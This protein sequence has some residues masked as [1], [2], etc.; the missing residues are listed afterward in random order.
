MKKLLSYPNYTYTYHIINHCYYNMRVAIST[1][2][3]KTYMLHT[4][5]VFQ[6]FQDGG[7]DRKNFT[8]FLTL[9][10]TCFAEN[11]VTMEYN[12][13]HKVSR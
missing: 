5:Y 12:F 11:L 8:K 9:C 1:T 7:T 13:K 2:I 4:I 6:T 10:P 3:F